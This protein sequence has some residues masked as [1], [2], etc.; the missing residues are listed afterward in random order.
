MPAVK[1]AVVHFL[2]TKNMSAD[3]IQHDLCVV[4]D[5]NVITE[6]TEK[7]KRSRVFKTGRTNVDVEEGSGW[8]L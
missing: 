4:Y 7:K 1:F 3:E 8:S 6:G 2:H 5:Q